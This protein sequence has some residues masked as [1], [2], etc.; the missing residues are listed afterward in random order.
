M[1]SHCRVWWIFQCNRYFVPLPSPIS[2]TLSKHPNVFWPHI[3]YKLRS[4]NI[5]TYSDNTTPISCTVS[6]HHNV[7]WPHN[8]YKL[9][10]LLKSKRLAIPRLLIHTLDKFIEIKENCKRRRSLS[11]LLENEHVEKISAK[12][13]WFFF[14]LLYL[15]LVSQKK[16]KETLN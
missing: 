10:S 4:P 9:H 13:M 15:Y 16:I 11:I 6:Q 8:S 12:R 1:L 3:S 2:Y 7:F 14:I 5:P